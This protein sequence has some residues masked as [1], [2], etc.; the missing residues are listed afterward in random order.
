MCS[1]D[2]VGYSTVR[3]GFRRPPEQ[4]RPRE[5]HHSGGRQRP[6][7]PIT[8]DGWVRER[9]PYPSNQPPWDSDVWFHVSDNSGWVTFAGVRATPTTPDPLGGYGKGTSP[10]PLDISCDGTYRN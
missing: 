7:Q 4:L 6:N 1:L 5:L 2:Y 3:L 9:T 10:A 8:V